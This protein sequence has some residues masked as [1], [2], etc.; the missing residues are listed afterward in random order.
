MSSH[1]LSIQQFRA[2]SYESFTV[3]PTSARWNIKEAS[4]VSWNVKPRAVVKSWDS[5]EWGSSIKILCFNLAWLARALTSECDE[6]ERDERCSFD[7]SGNSFALDLSWHF[8]AA[9][10]VLLESEERSENANVQ[11]CNSVDERTPNNEIQDYRQD[12]IG[13][14][15]VCW[16]ALSNNINIS[17]LFPLS[18]FRS[19][20]N[21]CVLYL[22]S[23]RTVA[24][25]LFL[26]IW[27]STAQ[28]T[29][30]CKH[31]RQ[32][33]SVPWFDFWKLIT[34]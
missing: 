2:I 16:F 13:Q 12:T 4:K 9:A 18:P 21:S 11:Q 27:N 25:R 8:L 33:Y 30:L 34:L 5:L 3:L 17:K 6:C 20:C 32:P 22:S 19:V 15:K 31:C 14:K 24:A 29:S 23:F 26:I 28:L 1:R 10:I 7:Y